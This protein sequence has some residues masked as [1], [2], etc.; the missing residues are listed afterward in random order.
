LIPNFSL[1][2]PLAGLLLLSFFTP[3]FLCLQEIL[4]SF[5]SF[6]LMA[7]ANC[8]SQATYYMYI[9]LL[10]IKNK[11]KIHSGLPQQKKLLQWLD[12]TSR[13]MKRE[14]I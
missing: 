4:A 1:F 13:D 5:F 11:I 9:L 7:S 2:V 6:G 8:S 14:M 3:T 12:Q 10:Y